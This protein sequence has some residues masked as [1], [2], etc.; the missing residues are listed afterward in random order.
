MASLI[1]I[2]TLF[3]LCF[4]ATQGFSAYMRPKSQ[5]SFYDWDGPSLSSSV[6]RMRQI[7]MAARE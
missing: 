3:L 1:L 7:K 4:N 5:R 2:L 6:K